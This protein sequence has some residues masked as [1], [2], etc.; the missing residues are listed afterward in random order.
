MSLSYKEVAEIL[1]IIE[2]SSLEEVV[3]E[4]EGTRL[5]VRRGGNATPMQA[6]LPM[7]KPAAAS[8]TPRGLDP[9]PAPTTLSQAAGGIEVR[10]PMVGTFFRRPSPQDPPFAEKGTRVRKGDPLCLIEV[11]KLYTTIASP[12]DGVVQDFM[13]EDGTL[14]A[15]DQLIV[16]LQSA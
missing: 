2:A 14:V 5:V 16:S 6:S 13:V 9:A 7:A 1:R 8:A 12:A 11:M 3:L 15:F 10:A 4:V